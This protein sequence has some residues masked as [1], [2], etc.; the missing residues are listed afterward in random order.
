[1]RLVTSSLLALLAATPAL[2]DD[3]YDAAPI[4][5]VTVFSQGA[6]MIRRVDLDLPP[7]EHRIFLPVET[8]NPGNPLPRL[9]A[10]EG[11]TIGAVAARKAPVTGA[12]AF[13]TEPQ[14][15]AF[16]A[17]EAAED[18]LKAH[19]SEKAARGARIEAL[20][21]RIAFLQAM[22]PDSTMSAQD[23]TE[24]AEVLTTDIAKSTAEMV[25]ARTE[26][27]AFAQGG[28]ALQQAMQEARR[29]FERSGAMLDVAGM[30]EVRVSA[31][32]P[33]PMTLE[34]TN[35]THDA[36]W[37]MDYD[38]NLDRKA[39]RVTIDRKLAVRHRS[40]TLWRDVMLTLSTSQPHGA[41]E[42]STV[43]PDKAGLS[44]PFNYS[45]DV[46]AI[47]AEARSMEA[48]AGAADMITASTEFDGLNLTYT[49]PQTVTI[50]GGE[51]V[52]LALDQLTTAANAKILAA[53][54]HDETA[55]LLA[56]I[57]NDTGEPLLP[58]EVNFLRDG[59][60]VGRS[61]IDV[62]PAGAE[63][64][65]P[66]GPMQQI[67]LATHFENNEEGDTGILT[68]S[69]TRSQ[70]ISFTVENLTG[71]T[72]DVRALFA[73]PFS[74]QERLTVKVKATPAPDE[75]DLEKRRGVSAWD[76]TLQPGE[77]RE[78]Q[79]EVD[80]NWPDGEMLFWNP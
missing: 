57:V 25:R 72:Q 32:K 51:S 33:G 17:L 76:L 26:L 54:R 44:Q 56:D 68:R 29:A 48:P 3:Y 19:Q 18:A 61:G 55:F 77:L 23:L 73:L 45:P 11:I 75:T 14:Q 65:L 64:T 80:L 60:F 70:K 50:G 12:E 59:H 20:K 49:Y 6:E 79:I 53:P 13:F 1:M 8:L 43:F 21:T 4:R 37:N 66:F 31:Q 9:M 24:V 46:S 15:R 63:A 28:E 67:R 78:V 74:E 2:A 16:E 22:Q 42:P 69:N 41:I 36:Y 58:G 35:F 38:I 34:L 62:I 47:K 39:G 10:S 71:E 27:D 7:G 40:E 52:E 30:L 5:A